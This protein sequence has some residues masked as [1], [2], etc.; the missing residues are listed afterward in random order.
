[1]LLG[2]EGF[3]HSPTPVAINGNQWY[4]ALTRLSNW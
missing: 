1:M 2:T 4:M 3:I